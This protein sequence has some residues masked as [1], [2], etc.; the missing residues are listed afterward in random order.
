MN[1]QEYCIDYKKPNKRGLACGF[2][3]L[4]TVHGPDYAKNLYLKMNPKAKVVRVLFKN[5][6][7]VWEQIE[8]K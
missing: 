2:F 7:G 8:V 1:L 6:R 3:Q 4:R 5:E